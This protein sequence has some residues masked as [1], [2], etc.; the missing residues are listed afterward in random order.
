MCVCIW[1]YIKC[2]WK[3]IHLNYKPVGTAR[4]KVS[5]ECVQIDARWKYYVAYNFV[6]FSSLFD[7]CKY[8]KYKVW[9]ILYYVCL[10]V[11]CDLYYNYILIVN[12]QQ[13][14]YI[15]QIFYFVFK[16]HTHTVTHIHACIHT[17]IHT[18]I[19]IQYCL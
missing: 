1:K 5:A 12:V 15:Y 13:H 6:H 3:W 2:G 17:Y 9:I 14:Y 19:Y 7:Q 4:K 18:C 10:Y 16:H 8:I 11:H